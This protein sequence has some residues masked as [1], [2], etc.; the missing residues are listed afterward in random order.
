MCVRERERESACSCN[1]YHM[2]AVCGYQTIREEDHRSSL[3]GHATS[4]GTENYEVRE[5]L[6]TTGSFGENFEH[7][8]SHFQLND[9]FFTTVVAIIA[10]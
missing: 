9:Y 5:L 4:K 6:S 7:L 8:T 1:K 3:P 2:S 10:E